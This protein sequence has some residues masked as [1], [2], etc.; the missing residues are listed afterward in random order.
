MNEQQ[1]ADLFSEQLDRMLQGQEPTLPANSGDVP[2][3]LNLSRQFGQINFQ[4]SAAAQAAFQSQLAGWFGNGASS[5][6][7]LGGF[8]KMLLLILGAATVVGGLAVGLLFTGVS[9]FDRPHTLF[10]KPAPAATTAP[11]AA[12]PTTPEAPALQ[13]T[14]EAVEPPAKPT[15]SSQGDSLPPTTQDSAGDTLP[16]PPPSD[17]LG[18]TIVVPTSTPTPNPTA[19]PTTPAT[20][21]SDVNAPTGDDSTATGT[22]GSEGDGTTEGTTPTG[23][24]DR[25]HGNDPDNFDEDNPGQSDGPPGSGSGGQDM[26][27]FSRGDNNGGGGNSGGGGGG[28]SGGGNSGNRGNSGGRGRN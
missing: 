5:A 27:D 25:G 17:S 10:D 16:P 7:T 21:E 19:T 12:P 22:S 20:V 4:P 26:S 14:S 13:N 8:S 9:T 18:E 23:D 2:D 1:L 15:T 24:H 11:T 28:N 3:L 6:A